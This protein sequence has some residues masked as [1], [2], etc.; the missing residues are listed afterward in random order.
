MEKK[1]ILV[2]LRTST[3]GQDLQ[4]Q[5][6]EMRDYVKSMG[7]DEGD[8]VY[9]ECTGAS[10][11]KLNDK[12]LNMI[13]IL[14]DYI[15]QGTIGCVAVWHINRLGRDDVLLIELKNL[16]IKHKIQFICKNPSLVLLNEDG[17]V[18]EGTELAFGLFATMVKQDMAEKKAK[19]KRAKSAMAKKGQWVGGRTLKFGYKVDENRFFV[20]DENDGA[21]VK[22]V[23]QLYSTGEYSSESLAK[24]LNDRG[25]KR[26]DGVPINS[27]FVVKLLK[28]NSYTGAPDEKNN[29]RVYPAII[30]KELYDKCRKIAESNKLVMRTGERIVPGA[31]LLKCH[32][33]GGTYTSNSRHFGCCRNMH[34]DCTNS[35][36][37]R[38]CVVDNILWRIS[39][40]LHLDY[41]LDLN[42]ETTGK[43]KEQIEV[44][45]QK[46]A[47]YMDKIKRTADLKQR[48]I[49]SFLDGLID[50]K[51][52]DSQLSKIEADA[53]G[54]KNEINT[55]TE[56]K[57]AI[58]GL[59]DNIDTDLN[60]LNLLNAMDIVEIAEQ[61]K[62][63]KYNIIHKH[64]LK[65][66]PSRMSFGIRDPRT[67][68]DNGVLFTIYTVNGAEMKYLFIPK[69]YKGHNLYIWN[70]TTQ[71]WVADM[72]EITDNI[73]VKKEAN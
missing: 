43:Y 25:I 24:E 14:K 73:Y 1:K 17:T 49:D 11:I 47:T 58:E 20:E 33:C 32:I 40:T 27:R 63:S 46:I 39:Y 56:Q 19:F 30:T 16:F 12:Y 37:I 65:V 26:N 69:F 53:Q 6:N 54:Y 9:L 31:K 36:K 8:C 13:D 60:E 72:V 15:K 34:K 10:A 45:E 57:A 61:D 4:D 50:K 71:E 29:M 23:Y 3:D 38:Q 70:D 59:I 66:V 44:I 7:Y 68:R 5:K 42:E 64:I 22:L 2:F 35:L 55:L 21:I 67:T 18:N 48:A 62:Q 51:K 41:L 28:C 52:R